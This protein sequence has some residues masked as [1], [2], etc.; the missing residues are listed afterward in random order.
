[1]NLQEPF[2]D[3]FTARWDT[4]YPI[5]PHMWPRWVILSHRRPWA[6]TKRSYRLSYS[7]IFMRFRITANPSHRPRR[8]VGASPTSIAAALKEK[9]Y[10]CEVLSYLLITPIFIFFSHFLVISYQKNFLV[11][12]EVKFSQCGVE[13]P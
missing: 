6:S 11:E 13:P 12:R 7:G 1:M 4:N 2:G 5:L 10:S 9:R 8:R 3:G